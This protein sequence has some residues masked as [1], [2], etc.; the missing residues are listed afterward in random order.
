MS[1]TMLA[2]YRRAQTLLKGIFTKNIAFNSTVFPIWIDDSDC[3]WYEREQK[4]GKEYRLV[5]AKT[6]SNE[7][8]FDHNILATILAEKV[9]QEVDANNLPIHQV[10]V[11]LEEPFTISEEASEVSAT[12]KS[13]ILHFTAFNNRW[14]Y[15]TRTGN[16]MA[17]DFKTPDCAVSPDGKQGIFI[18]DFNLWH[19]YLETGEER[20]L[21]Q[22]GEE[23]Y[24]YGIGVGCFAPADYTDVQIRWSPDSTRIFAVQRDTRQ[25]K[26]VPNI[27]Y[28]PQDGSVR[29][30]LLENKLAYP[31]DDNIETLRL[32]SI[33]IKSGQQQEANY[34]HVP[35]T[36]NT[37]S[38]FSTNLGWWSNDNRRTYFV[39]VER[40]YK[41]AR[42]VEFDTH[43]GTTRIL[44]EETTD[45]HISLM[46]NNDECPELVPL[47]ETSELLWF[48]ERSGWPHLYLYDLETGELKKVVT[49]GEWLVRNV[50]KVDAKRREIFVQTAARTLDRDPYYRDLCRIHMDTGEITQLI[51]S[52]HEYW[53]VTQNH[54][55][56]M[57]AKMIGRDVSSACGVA[58]TGNFA[59]V[60][61]SRADDIPVTLLLDR[62]GQLVLEL[63]TADV[64]ALP[65][66]W[67]WPEPVKLIAADGTT[68]IYGLVFRPSYFS[69]D[70]TYPVISSVFNVPDLPH[71]P[72]GSFTNGGS[73]GMQYLDGAALAELGF[74][75]VQIDGRGT[76]YRS[77][78]F[79]DE[80]YGWVESASN[81]DDHI[82]GIQQLAKRYPYMDL[83]R[84]GITNHPLGGGGVVNALLLHPDFYKVGV[85]MS[86][87]DSRFLSAEL[88]GEKYEG[89]TGRLENY[90]YP[91]EHVEKLEG[92]LLLMNMMLDR[93]APVAS[94]FRIVDALQKA[95]KDFDLL[96][97]PVLGYSYM[98]R[99]AWDYLV[100]HLQGT[101][102][103][104]E[105]K[106]TT[107]F[108]GLGL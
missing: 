4:S 10:T 83:E 84:V 66:N 6:A 87:Y 85:A 48:S 18:R 15:H 33:D 35:V 92:K 56:T 88:C 55:G 46:L 60:T 96:L 30:Q 104:K 25:V 108:D 37:G 76:P 65:D 70:R 16:C 97:L 31:G 53:T 3:F 74:I 34:R 63:E 27:Q 38:F 72:K 44:F 45:T 54:I 81:L 98:V 28:V 1:D 78:A 75:V 62:H 99:H 23:D 19:R 13:V 77:K 29:P 105:F 5:D 100:K 91:E 73:F 103:P 11:E 59:V 106:L 102:P 57:Y 94:V 86:S 49:Q 71:V 101:E 7:V 52:D 36:R 90:Q 20:A 43:T 69:S 95:N 22:D 41:T 89:N 67:Q 2:R 12:K 24:V 39:D 9:T 32:L 58:P 47:P 82:A 50:I 51:S 21:T 68:D 42:V 93:H 64:T 61:R 80:S 107:V 40:N 79:H 26:T 8:A 14:G 17:V